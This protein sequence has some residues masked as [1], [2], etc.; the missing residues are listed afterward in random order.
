MSYLCFKYGNINDDDIKQ[1]NNNH[2]NDDMDDN[3]D[4]CKFNKKM[5]EMY[6][7]VLND[8][9]LLNDKPCIVTFS[10]NIN[11]NS[12]KIRNGEDNKIYLSGKLSSAPLPG[13]V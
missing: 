1:D 4:D 8:E 11:I 5:I 2:I 6:S 7:Y 13:L 3:D 9:T 10:N 12:L